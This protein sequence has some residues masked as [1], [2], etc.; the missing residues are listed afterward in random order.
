VPG[1]EQIGARAH[2]RQPERAILGGR[3]VVG[4]TPTILPLMVPPSATA[5]TSDAAGYHPGAASRLASPTLRA[6]IPV[7]IRLEADE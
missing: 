3:N 4:I 5:I 6:T 1:H 7:V 2:V